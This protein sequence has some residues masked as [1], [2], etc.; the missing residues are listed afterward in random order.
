MKVFAHQRRRNPS[1]E[2]I[3]VRPTPGQAVC[4]E[5]GRAY[6]LGPEADWVCPRCGPSFPLPTSTGPNDSTLPAHRTRRS[7]LR[8]QLPLLALV[9][10]L[11]LVS[12]FVLLL[13]RISDWQQTGIRPSNLWQQST[14]EASPVSE[15]EAASDA[16]GT[17]SDPPNSL[18]P[19]VT[20]SEERSAEAENRPPE[21]PPP[22]SAGA[23]MLTDLLRSP[24][25]HLQ[26]ELQL[27]CQFVRNIESDTDWRISIPEGDMQQPSSR[28][29]LQDPRGEK[30]SQVFV[31]TGSQAEQVVPW[32]RQG[33]WLQ[34]KGTVVMRLDRPAPVP[35][36]GFLIREIQPA[37]KSLNPTRTTGPEATSAQKG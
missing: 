24:R 21:G 28:L 23:L 22:P 18:D 37:A 26:Q 27:D 29:E 34:I 17:P 10:S 16:P 31:A 11:S 20:G 30:I 14:T 4:S 6:P 3:D 32:I 8:R 35:V 13:V 19:T 15:T 5:C 9:V 1:A 36:W 7:F 2:I 25:P 12:L 33:D